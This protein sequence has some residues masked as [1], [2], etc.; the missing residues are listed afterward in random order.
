LFDAT[1]QTEKNIALAEDVLE[2]VREQAQAEEKTADEV[3]E[4][5][6]RRELARKAF[7]RIRREAEIR[8]GGM[9]DEEVDRTVEKAVHEW[10]TEQRGR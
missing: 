9:T 8:R 5:A 3:V 1:M 2:R 10:R 6:V 7:E 4:Q